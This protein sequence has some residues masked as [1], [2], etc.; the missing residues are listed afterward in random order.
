[1]MGR[2]SNTSSAWLP[3]VATA[4]RGVVRQG[5]AAGRCTHTLVIVLLQILRI[6]ATEPNSNYGVRGLLLF[7]Y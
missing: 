1:M 5:G 7:T 6:M 2:G 3:S 4:R